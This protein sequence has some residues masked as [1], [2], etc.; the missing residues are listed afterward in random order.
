MS[1]IDPF[2]AEPQDV[3]AEM[4]LFLGPT[5]GLLTRNRPVGDEAGRQL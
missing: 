2:A 5:P 4:G 3:F 1:F